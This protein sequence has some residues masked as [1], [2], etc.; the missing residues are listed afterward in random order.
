MSSSNILWLMAYNIIIV[1]SQRSMPG[2]G[3][4][5]P[6]MEGG[7]PGMGGDMP[8]MGGGMPR[9]GGGML[10]MGGGGQQL[11]AAQLQ[12]LLQRKAQQELREK[13][14]KAA[15]ARMLLST[16]SHDGIMEDQVSFA[17]GDVA[18]NRW[19]WNEM[20]YAFSL[21]LSAILFVAIKIIFKYFFGVCSITLL[22]G[23]SVLVG[24]SFVYRTVYKKN[25][26]AQVLC[27]DL[28]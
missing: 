27:I 9:M 25:R 8:G 22:L 13:M 4:G 14:I 15:A 18:T 24:F 23:R 7:M 10:G 17:I 28:F 12:Q 3:G 5:M 11:T 21:C 19:G 6:G 16:S 26:S 2:M 1:Q 20:N